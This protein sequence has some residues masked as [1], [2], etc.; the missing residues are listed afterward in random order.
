MPAGEQQYY[1]HLEL[2]S[3]SMHKTERKEKLNQLTSLISK[4][5]ISLSSSPAD[6]TAAGIATAGPMPITAG[7]TPTAAK[8]LQHKPSTT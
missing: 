5:S 4:R 7:S 1:N 8:V 6:L 3:N 2:R